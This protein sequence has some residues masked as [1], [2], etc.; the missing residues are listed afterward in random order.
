MEFASEEQ[1]KERLEAARKELSNMS[2]SSGG[3]GGSGTQ[4]AA[5]ARLNQYK[6]CGRCMGSG[7]IQTESDMHIVRTDCCPTCDG[8]GLLMANGS[9]LPQESGACSGMQKASEHVNSKVLEK[10]PTEKEKL[11]A[12]REKLLAFTAKAEK[13]QTLK[14]KGNEFFANKEY[15]S[16][17]QQ[18]TACVACKGAEVSEKKIAVTALSNRALSYLT[19]LELGNVSNESIDGCGWF[20]SIEKDCT[21]GLGYVDDLAKALK[22]DV[23]NDPEGILRSHYVKLLF[24]RATARRS[25]DIGNA[26]GAEDDLKQALELEPDNQK[27]KS[28]LEEI[29][30]VVLE[31]LD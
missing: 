2:V 30:A 11:L 14:A 26:D 13:M 6:T 29:Q 28:A 7:E 24:R 15:H 12:E 22:L 3:G 31:E 8:E 4:Q 16:A 21:T 19:L 25:D 18:Y 5:N 9:K 1:K 10:V 20:Q 27:V 23:G 17:I